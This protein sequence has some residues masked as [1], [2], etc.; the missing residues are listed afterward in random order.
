MAEGSKKVNI[1]D[2]ST[3]KTS[4]EPLLEIFKFIPA[5]VVHFRVFAT[6]H[7]HDRE[8]ALA[9]EKALGFPLNEAI[10]TNV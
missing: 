9:A 5:K 10:T 6:S 2:P 7:D 8:L 1:F 4:P 3:G